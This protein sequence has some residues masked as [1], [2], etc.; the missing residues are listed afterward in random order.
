MGRMIFFRFFC[1]IFLFVMYPESC[2]PTKV[3]AKGSIAYAAQK[4]VLVVP[5]TPRQFIPKPTYYYLV[6]Y[7]KGLVKIKS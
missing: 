7:P 5:Q 3:V 6:W 4:I 2:E 1:S